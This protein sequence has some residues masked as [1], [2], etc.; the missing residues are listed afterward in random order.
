MPKTL[1][2][3]SAAGRPI[4]TTNVIGCNEAIINKKTGELCRVKNVKSLVLKLD[5]LIKN[6]KL[7]EYY[8]KNG[9]NLAIKN[10]DIKEVTK[11]M[12]SI[13]KS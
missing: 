6:K 5:K 2:E 1:L 7:R 13:Y 10:Y 9:R 8:G 4:V 11:K 3:A 12:I